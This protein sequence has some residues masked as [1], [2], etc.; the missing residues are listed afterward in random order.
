MILVP[1]LCPGTSC[2]RGS[3]SLWDP[4][5]AAPRRQCVPG[6]NPGTTKGWAGPGNDKDSGQSLLQVVPF[7][8]AIQRRTLNSKNRRRLALVPVGMGERAQDVP[9]LELGQRVRPVGGLD[10]RDRPAHLQRR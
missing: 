5:E 1:G 8:L 9:F 3:A 7:N 6:R 2:L 4:N 10:L